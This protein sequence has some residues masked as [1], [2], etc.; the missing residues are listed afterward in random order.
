MPLYQ[1]ASQQQPEVIF[2]PAV[3]TP[4]VVIVIVYNATSAIASIVAVLEISA[5]AT[6]VIALMNV[7]TCASST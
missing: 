5:S 2:A 4:A 3:F 7:N 6:V 1:V